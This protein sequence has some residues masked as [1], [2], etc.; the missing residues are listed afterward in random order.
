MA[1]AFA[2]TPVLTLLRTAAAQCGP[3]GERLVAV[4]AADYP[5]A[6]ERRPAQLLRASGARSEDLDRLL[7]MAGFADTDDLRRQ[8]GREANRRLT[9]PDL[10][11]TRRDGEAQDRSPLRRTLDREQQNLAGT[12]N[13]L[14]ANGALELAAEAILAGRRRWIFGD[15][16]SIGYAALLASDLTSSL[17]DVTLIQ[18]GSGAAVNAISDAHPSDVLVAYSFRSYSQLT[19]GVARQ[20]QALGATVIALTDSYDSPVCAT[21]HHVLAINTRSESPRHS[22]TAVTAVGHIL[23]SLAAAG[24][25]GAGRRD[26]RRA[27]LARALQCYAD[28]AAAEAPAVTRPVTAAPTDVAILP[29]ADP[30]RST[31]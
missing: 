29:Q 25:K 6:L 12:L 27:E 8:A 14:Q 11:F 13:S 1:T 19:L 2:P 15:L 17:R 26:R 31:S 20:F 10:R 4:I 3:A 9:P 18:P 7:A 21:A 16:K 24:A 23:A 28:D 5:A 30:E 22:P